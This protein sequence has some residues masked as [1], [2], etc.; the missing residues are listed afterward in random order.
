LFDVRF[1]AFGNV[2]HRELR[3]VCRDLRPNNTSHDYA[4]LFLTGGLVASIL[5]GKV[6]PEW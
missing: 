4:T 2:Y 5:G 1:S 3:G 6:K